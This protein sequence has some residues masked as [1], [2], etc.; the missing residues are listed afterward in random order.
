M[1]EDIVNSYLSKIWRQYS[2]GLRNV[3]FTDDDGRTTETHATCM[4][5]RYA[6]SKTITFR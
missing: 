4:I 6:A 3:S 1:C 5:V 2:W